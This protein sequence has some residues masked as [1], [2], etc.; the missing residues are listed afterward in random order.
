MESFNSSPLPLSL[1]DVSLNM[2]SIRSLSK[3]TH[4]DPNVKHPSPPRAQVKDRAEDDI[5]VQPPTQTSDQSAEHFDELTILPVGHTRES[6][7]SSIERLPTEIL[8]AIISHVGGHLGSPSYSKLEATRNWNALLRHPRRKNISDLA[9]VSPVWRRLVQERIFRHIKLQGTQAALAECAD[10]LLKH[11]HLQSHLRHLQIIVPIWETKKGVVCQRH[12]PDLPGVESRSSIFRGTF[13][14]PIAQGIINDQQAEVSQIFQPATHNAT[15]SEIFGAAQ[16][17]FPELHALTIEGG[18]CKR[19]PQIEYFLAQPTNSFLQTGPSG[20]PSSQ[21]K[22]PPP[23]PPSP[24]RSLPSLSSVKVFILKG[25]WN[26]IRQPSELDIIHRALPNIQELHCI[27]HAPKTDAY[28]TMST[29]LRADIFP[30]T[31]RHLNICLEG[32][33]TKNTSSLAKWRKVYPA[34]HIC[35]DIGSMMTQLESLA[36]TGRVCGALF[37]TAVKAAEQMRAGFVRLKRVDV[38][39]QNVCRDASASNDGTGIHNWPFI[40]AFEV[41]VIQAMRALAVFPEVKYMRIR[42][43]DLD[44]PDPLLNPIF[45]L[46]GNKAWG[47]WSTEILGLLHT[48]R[49]EVRFEGAQHESAYR[50]LSLRGGSRRSHSVEHYSEMAQSLG[51]VLL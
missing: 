39:V 4:R 23:L 6:S 16:V 35:R 19:P 20:S 33:Y 32:L 5:S 2:P 49:P 10:F 1:D 22:L 25:A 42:F 34:Y 36:F 41:L 48:A 45:H 12:A 46:E 9:L 26:I 31:I 27:Y 50:G 37:S 21:P 44:S 7:C 8:E 28:T 38:I 47:F 11:T 18:H 13:G 30:L 51:R 3:S 24:H 29:A 40:Q 17:L 14:Q 43:I 15:L